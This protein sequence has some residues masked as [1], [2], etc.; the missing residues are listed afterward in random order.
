MFFCRYLII[1]KPRFPKRTHR[2]WWFLTILFGELLRMKRNTFC[3]FLRNL[4]KTGSIAPNVNFY[5]KHVGSKLTKIYSF[6]TQN[7][8]T[9]GLFKNYIKMNYDYAALKWGQTKFAL[10]A[11]LLLMCSLLVWGEGDVHTT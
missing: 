1:K 2:N 11:P 6:S 9:E 4:R 3:A 7:Q 5:T 10:R 8:K